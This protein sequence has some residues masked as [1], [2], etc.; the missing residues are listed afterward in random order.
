MLRK[1]R[2]AEYPQ[3]I[4]VIVCCFNS[5]TRIGATLKH[6]ALQQ[7]PPLIGY[8]VILVDNN[9]QDD[10]AGHAETVWTETNTILPLRILNE[11]RQGLAY[12]RMKG[13]QSA[14]YRYLVFCDDDNWLPPDYVIRVADFFED[15][16]TYGL[17]GGSSEA[18]SDVALPPW[19]ESQRSAYACGQQCMQSMDVTG[20]EFLWGA[21]IS[22]RKVLFEKIYDAAFPVQFTGR[23]GKALVSGDDD[24]INGRTWLSGYRVWYNDELRLRHYIEP[25]RLNMQYAEKIFQNFQQQG[26]LRGAYFR[27]Y[28][29][30]E[31]NTLQ[32][33]GCLLF[34]LYNW[35]AGSMSHNESRQRV[36]RSYLYLLIGWKALEVKENQIMYRFYQWTKHHRVKRVH[37]TSFKTSDQ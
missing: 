18:V 6:L 33:A 21:G 19:F 24:E 9:S 28:R 36:A 10:T 7:L 37:L 34:A 4:S 11:A 35:G 17:I 31:M 27:M 14:H 2:L 16:P 22:G 8:E 23:N 25:A 3:G 26:T 15:H 30:S 12:A 13:V 29:L 32:K 20:K 5:K 1:T